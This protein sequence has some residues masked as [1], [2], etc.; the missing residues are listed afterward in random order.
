MPSRRGKKKAATIAA[1][2]GPVD[3]VLAKGLSHPTRGEILAFLAEHEIGSPAEME[4]AGLGRNGRGKREG[5]KLAHISYHVRVLEKMGLVKFAYS[6]PV[7]G[8]NEHFYIPNARMLLTVED[9][10]KLPR[11][12]KNDVSIAALEETFGLA[13]KAISAGTFDSFNE[14]A[15]INLTLRLDEETF[16]LLAEEMTEFALKRC[17]QLQAECVGRVEGDL[18]KLRNFSASML[19]YESA[20]P[21][22]PE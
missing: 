5:K 19:L 22:R 13:S 15:V 4:R 20:R 18:S 9:W 14:R 3:G 16:K 17:E 12:A 21:V 1:S 11:S 7:R 8:A 10:S 2:G 6:R